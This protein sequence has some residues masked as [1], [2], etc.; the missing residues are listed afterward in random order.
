MTRP[1]IIYIAGHA[2]TGSTIVDAALSQLNTV[3]SLGELSHLPT[4]LLR[5]LPCTCGASLTECTAWTNVVD[6]TRAFDLEE[7]E[8]ATRL[9]EQ[10]MLPGRTADVPATYRTFWND[11]LLAAAED[12]SSPYLVDASKSL[13]QFRKRR[14]ALSEC[15]FDVRVIHTA[16][17]VAG[18]V[19]SS[20][21]GPGDVLGER[22]TPTFAG[23]RAL[24]GLILS[25]TQARID[26]RTVE[27]S[28]RVELDAFSAEPAATI[29]RCVA[30]L[31]IESSTT[32]GP[33]EAGHAIGGNRHR[34]TG[35]SELEV[36]QSRPIDDACEN[37]R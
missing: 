21:T 3:A 26:R 5:D 10:S 19:R 7:I 1:T 30:E 35:V 11:V 23:P 24:L 27:F 34:H 20:T 33:L 31:A 15:G 28:T 29:E 16:R 14:A 12:R 8:A 9:V 4:F 37:D 17:D 25:N 2:R 36:T 32:L 13:V 22:W 18:V 6:A